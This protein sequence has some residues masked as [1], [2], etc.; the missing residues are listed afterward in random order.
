MSDIVDAAERAQ[1][2]DH[3]SSF[4]VSAPAG[5]GKT[6]LLIQRYLCLLSRVQRPEQVLAITFTRKAAAEMRERVLEAL[7]AAAEGTP[8]AGAHEQVTRDLA[9]AALEADERGGWHLV[10]DI[11]RL[12]IKT[13]DSFCAGLTRQMPVLSQLGGQV[14]IEDDV[15]SL[16]LEAVAELFELVDSDHPVAEDL[17]ALMLHFDNDWERLQELLVAMLG[18]REQWRSYV[19]VHYEPQRAEQHLVTAVEDVVRGEL[20]T[21]EQMLAPYAAELLDL[22]QFAATNLAQSPLEIFPASEPEDLSGWREITNLLF[23][24]SGGWRKSLSKT[25]GFP[26]GKGEPAERKAQLQ[27]LL[28]ELPQVPGLEAAANGIAHLPQIE[29]GSTSWQLV[30]HLSRL[31]PMLAAELLLVFRK[32]GVVDHSQVA[33]SAL[34]ALGEDETPTDLALRLDYCIEHILVDEFQDTAVNQYELLHKLTRGWGEHNAAQPEAPRT[35]LIVGD[36][37]QSIYGFR[38]ANVGLLLKAQLEG[39]NG[40]PLKPLHLRSNFR[41]DQ[42]MV[43]WV[44]NTFERAFPAQNNMNRSEVKFSPATAVRAAAQE[45]AVVVHVFVDDDARQAEV[46]FVCAGIAQAHATNPEHSIAVLGRTRTH[47]QPIISQLKGMDIPFNAQDLDS[48]ADSPVVADLLTLCR[49]LANSADRLAWMALLRAPWCG[50]E[51]ADLL[52]LA[53]C[54]NAPRYTTL[55]EILDNSA[56]QKNLSV[57]GQ[58]R[59]QL[60]AAP[61]RQARAKRDRLALRVWVEQLWVGLGGPACAPDELALEDA[62]NFLQ[63]LEEAQALG[64]GLDIPWLERK[65]AKRY[66][67]GGDA[68]SKIQI[69][70]LHKAKGLEFDWVFIP[71]LDRQTRSDGRQILLWDEISDTAGNRSFL[72]AADDRSKPGVATLYNYLGERRKHKSRLEGTRLLY[73][74]ATRAISH[75]VLTAGLRWEEQKE[76]VKA[77]TRNSLLHAIWPSIEAAAVIHREAPALFSPDQKRRDKLLLRRDTTTLKP[78]VDL[79]KNALA[80]GADAPEGNVPQRSDNHIER[81]T[82]TV[83]HLAMEILSQQELLPETVTAVDRVLWRRALQRENLYAESLESALRNVEEAVV[84]TLRKGGE[85]RWVLSAQHREAH[86]EWPLTTVGSNGLARDIVVDRCF[87]DAKTGTRW[88]VDY[89]NSRPQPDEAVDDFMARE[90]ATYSEQLQGYR[91]AVSQL[92]DQPVR[93]AL[94]FT[95]LGELFPLVGLDL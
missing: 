64:L 57:D 86:S 61:L 89:K 56:W 77:P 55:W 24:K 66:M 27:A 34:V 47:L 84:S 91:D 22:S 28:K 70:T 11:A 9:L 8:C 26:T 81:A 46:D 18:R 72:L 90:A 31:L 93:C 44:N 6:E 43:D 37:M 92:G 41:S 35:L 63:L 65:L 12:N 58:A 80:S 75:L 88:I 30:L 40:V 68:Q 17:A 50:L 45:P 25:M 16:Y 33:Q 7:R 4:C 14:G 23:T 69:M 52:Q 36:G 87:V 78:L 3:T 1:A 48:L 79:P 49:V 74:G 95:A 54:G 67:S 59:L 76:C 73:V 83:V 60:V 62:E 94:F 20:R 10:R 71:Q 38:G 21:V 32:H 19:G 82:G 39:F 85:G 13:I 29:A 5:S 2:L 51:L 42:G 15:E 53:Q